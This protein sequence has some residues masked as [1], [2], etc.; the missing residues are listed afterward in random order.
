MKNRILAWL[1]LAYHF[2][3]HVAFR[4]PVRALGRSRD[5][6]RFTRA[7]VPE[8]YIALELAER[9]ALPGFMACIHCGLCAVACPAL[10]EAPA[11]AWTEAWTFVAGPSRALD[12]ASLVDLPPCTRC[13]EC[14]DVCPTGVPIT[15]LAALVRHIAARGAADLPQ[16]GEVA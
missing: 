16:S 13:A 14:E 4:L 8:G 15:S 3:I 7:V 10:R 9:T 5:A 12:R 1:N 11:A 2:A 6:T